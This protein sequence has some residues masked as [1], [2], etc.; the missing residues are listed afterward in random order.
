MSSEDGEESKEQG[1][2]KS[3]IEELIAQED[4]QL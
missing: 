1:S 3:K 2:V 4:S